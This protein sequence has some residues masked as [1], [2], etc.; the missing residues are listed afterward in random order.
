M[1]TSYSTFQVGWQSSY[2]SCSCSYVNFF[3][4][5]TLNDKV[6]HKLAD[7]A[8]LAHEAFKRWLFFLRLYC[9]YTRDI[10][11]I[12]VSTMQQ[13]LNQVCSKD[14]RGLESKDGE[15]TE[16]MAAFWKVSFC[17]I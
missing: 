12:N 15:L 7:V 5:M 10:P 8:L 11:E 16:R 1:Y 14:N 2:L 6:C 13:C 4:I 17:R 3:K 9:L